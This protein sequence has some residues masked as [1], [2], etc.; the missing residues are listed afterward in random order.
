MVAAYRIGENSSKIIAGY[1]C[2]SNGK[3]MDDLLAY[4]NG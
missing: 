4:L 3:P 1:V 2:V